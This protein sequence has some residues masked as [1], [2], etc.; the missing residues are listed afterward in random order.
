M[1]FARLPQSIV[2]HWL[3]VPIQWP[4]LHRY[5]R[6]FP[7]RLLYKEGLFMVRNLGLFQ[8]RRSQP[9]LLTYCL[10][11]QGPQVS[12][13]WVFSTALKQGELSSTICLRFYEELQL[14]H[15]RYHRSAAARLARWRL[16]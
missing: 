6:L 5:L 3:T 12:L 4:L 9:T 11:P 14:K 1:F 10:I 8:P 2:L 13:R 15:K 7:P 16:Q